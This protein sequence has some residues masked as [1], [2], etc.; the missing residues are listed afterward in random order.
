VQLL[1]PK[2][3]NPRRAAL[4]IAQL[5]GISAKPDGQP[6][7]RQSEPP[8]RMLETRDERPAEA[9]SDAAE[10]ER[11]G[12]LF[13]RP[14]TFTLQLGP[15]TADDGSAASQFVE[16]HGLA[17]E[18]LS[19]L[20]AG[21]GLRGS[22]KDR[23]AFP[24]RNVDGEIVAYVGRDVGLLAGEDEPLYKLPAKFH[25]EFELFGWD[26]AQ[27]FDRIVLVDDFL[28]VV[29]F[30]GEASK[31]G[32][33]G[34]G[35][36]SLMGD[37]ISDRQLELLMETQPEVIVCFGDA[38]GAAQVAAQVALAGLWVRVERGAAVNVPE[39]DSDDFCHVF[40]KV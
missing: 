14:L 5:S 31:F 29:K 35:V 10:V 25:P 34:F 9:V 40:G 6:M 12:R 32:E 38:D 1:D 11:D 2:L 18:R 21:M 3:E 30:G 17:Y 28:P 13:N 16:E 26:V 20:G 33:T 39:V 4:Q 24:I 27:Y 7:S 22:M 8:V 23:L 37:A 36:A 15:V 19:E